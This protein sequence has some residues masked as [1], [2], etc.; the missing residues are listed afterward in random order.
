MENQFSGYP[1]F[2][3]TPIWG[4]LWGG[5]WKSTKNIKKSLWNLPKLHSLISPQFAHVQNQLESSETAKMVKM[6]QKHSEAFTSSWLGNV[7]SFP[8][9]N[10][11]LVG[12]VNPPEKYESQLGWLFP[13][14]GKIK[15]IFQTTNQIQKPRKIASSQHH[16][17]IW[18]K[19]Q[20]TPPPK[21]S[22]VDPGRPVAVG[23][24]VVMVP[25]GSC[26]NRSPKTIEKIT[27]PWWEC[28]FLTPESS[29]HNGIGSLQLLK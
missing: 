20:R 21:T 26:K 10:H 13:I 12:G 25:S 8:Q 22:A 29:C 7:Q 17:S 9:Q 11:S 4:F 3:E 19:R 28:D 24:V 1:Y 5:C 15:V 18:P 14:Y 23:S 27:F 16:L 2:E 6:F